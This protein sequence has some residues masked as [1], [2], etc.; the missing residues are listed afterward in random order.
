[1]TLDALE[2]L[3]RVVRPAQQVLDQPRVVEGLTGRRALA[4]VDHVRAREQG[5][6]R[7]ERRGEQQRA[8]RERQRDAGPQREVTPWRRDEGR[9]GSDVLRSTPFTAPTAGSR[10]RAP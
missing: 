7:R 9:H 8:R 4:L 3:P 5:G 1:L 6:G 2:R 10:G